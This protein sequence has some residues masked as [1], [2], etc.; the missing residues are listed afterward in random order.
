MG[1]RARLTGLNVVGLKRRG[2][3]SD[4]IRRLRTAYESCSTAKGTLAERVE[5]AS[6]SSSATTRRCSEIVASSAREAAA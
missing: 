2:L 5:R 6:A 1:D 4:D 3:T